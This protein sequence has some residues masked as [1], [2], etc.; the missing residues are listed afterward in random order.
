M[1]APDWY[2]RGLPN[3]WLP[4]AQMKTA[5]PPLAA[6]RTHGSRIVLADG[7]E[8]VDG[9]ASW[10]T[11]VHGY[12]HPHICES[13]ERQLG[14]MPHLMLDGLVHEQAATLAARLAG[15][16]P[17]DLN[18]VF[19]SDS[20]S[21]AVDVA[22]TMAA[23][24]WLNRGET[25]RTKF[26][27]FRGGYHGDRLAAMSAC[28]SDEGMHPRFGGVV[29]AQHILELP[30]DDAGE[31]ALHAFLSSHAHKLAGIIVEPLVQGAGGM[32]FNDEMCLRRLRRAADSHGLILI[33]DEIF[34]GF[35]RTGPMFACCID[36]AVPDI[37]TLGKALSG[38]ALP[39]AATVASQRIFDGFWSDD[40]SQALM[41]GPT[42]MGNPLACAAANASL[43]LFERE[44]RCLQSAEIAKKLTLGLGP[45]IE[46]PGV[47]DVRVRGAIGVV[48]LNAI[49]DTNALNHRFVD[50]GVWIKPFRNIVYLTPALT[51]ADE[52]L[53]YLTG[54]IIRVLRAWC[55]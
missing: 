17:G 37:I 25:N 44:P 4:Y 27:A 40:A 3:L 47:K 41:H 26:L 6:V 5:D 22:M 14:I 20:G 53:A 23:Q 21:V 49:G 33:F 15:L 50:A 11:A 48:E 45:C 34:T 54:A 52:D 31:A 30:R 36:G 10:W 2:A 29:P 28:D 38:G 55:G 12:N 51:I 13:I 7:R 16:L 32:I 8:L 19:F 24:Y 46:L 1:S 35:A 42:F 43:D 9:I 39:L 18:H